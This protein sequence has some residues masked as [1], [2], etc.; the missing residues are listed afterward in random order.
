V[1]RSARQNGV[2]ESIEAFPPVQPFVRSVPK[3][4]PCARAWPTNKK[5]SDWRF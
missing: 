4:A 2:A 5:Y 1:K 3:P